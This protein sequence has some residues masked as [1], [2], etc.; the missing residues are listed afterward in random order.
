MDRFPAG[1]RRGFRWLRT[2][3]ALRVR[4]APLQPAGTPLGDPPR[5]EPSS[6]A[7]QTVTPGR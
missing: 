7:P 4:R 2:E 5:A 1:D 6:A 3:H